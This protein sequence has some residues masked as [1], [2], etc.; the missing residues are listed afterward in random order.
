MKKWIL[1]IVLFIVIIVGIMIK[2]Y[3]SSVEP[4]KAAEKKAVA[5]ANE[6]T[7]LSKV[8]DFH[9]YSGLETIDVI[10][11]K[12]KKGEKIIIWIPEKS[13]KLVVKKASDGLTKE[14]AIQ[15]LLEEKNPKKIISV[16]LG[17]EKNIPLWE[18][19]YRS[20]NNLINYYYIDFESGEWL[21]KIEN[22]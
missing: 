15:K 22:L 3:F 16:R 2:V 6:K 10:E 4:L 8:V 17:M 19:Y 14:E 7:S 20:E 21:K 9:I 11:G 18:I 13:K 1:F 12:D 5:L